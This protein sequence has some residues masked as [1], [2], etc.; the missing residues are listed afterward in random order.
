VFVSWSVRGR[1][2]CHQ[3]AC[4]VEGPVVSLRARCAPM[5]VRAD[6]VRVFPV[7]RT[8]FRACSPSTSYF[9]S[10]G[11]GPNLTDRLE[12]PTQWDAPRVAS[13]RAN[14]CQTS[15]SNRDRGWRRSRSTSHAP[16]QG[17]SASATLPLPTRRSGGP[18]SLL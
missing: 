13:L 7:S 15:S 18:S 2:S 3:Q 10:T 1:D 6:T 16:L 4:P 12:T 14:I 8:F 17:R 11:F 5:P 9:P